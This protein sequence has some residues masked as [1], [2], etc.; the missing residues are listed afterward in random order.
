MF[1]KSSPIRACPISG[2]SSSTINTGSSRSV[3]RN[4]DGTSGRICGD[5]ARSCTPASRPAEATCSAWRKWTGTQFLHRTF[6]PCF[7]SSRNAC[8]HGTCTNIPGICPRTA[9]RRNVMKSP[10]GKSS[11][12]ACHAR[13]DGARLAFRLRPRP[14]RRRGGESVL[15]DHAGDLLPHDEQL[16]F[17]SWVAPK[18]ATL[19]ERRPAERGFSGCSDA[20]DVV[21]G[22]K[23]GRQSL[24]AALPAP[25]SC[26]TSRDDTSAG[27]TV[28]QKLPVA[29]EERP[30]NP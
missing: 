18:L 6:S 13:H 26:I 7:S 28:M 16:I 20:D 27:Q 19:L 11:S 23:V 4:R 5:C 12:S 24:A 29:I 1:A 22:E 30:K 2:Y 21:G 10:C 25:G 9:K 8:L 3:S 17:T 14:G 15:R